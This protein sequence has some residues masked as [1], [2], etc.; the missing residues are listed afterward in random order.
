MEREKYESDLTAREKRQK[1]LETIRSLHGKKRAEYLWTYYRSWLLATLLAAF[2]VFVLIYSWQ[3]RHT[4]V[5]LSIAVADAEYSAHGEKEEKLREDLLGALGDGKARERINLDTT[6][7]SG[8]DSG[9]ALKRMTVVGAGNTDLLICDRQTWKEYQSQGAFQ[10]WE[11]FLGESWEQYRDLF[12]DGQ[13]DLSESPR[14]ESYGL[15]SYEPVCA[16]VLQ[17]TDKKE[18]VCGFLDFFFS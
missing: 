2:G 10:E 15:T 8:D 12:Q 16:A 11:D 1:R 4:R 6:L 3:N 17:D 13:L 9:M 18:E 5:I 14:W 7:R